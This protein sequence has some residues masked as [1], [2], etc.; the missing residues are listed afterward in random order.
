MCAVS[1]ASLFWSESSNKMTYF[2]MRHKMHIWLSD[3]YM[4]LMNKPH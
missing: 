2:T 3:E 4:H 1:M